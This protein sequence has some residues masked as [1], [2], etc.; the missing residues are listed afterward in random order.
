[1]KN[2]FR[3]TSTHD[4]L[5]L[6]RY[7]MVAPKMVSTW[8][9]PQHGKKDIQ[10]K[11]WLY[12]FLMTASKQI[13]RISYKIMWVSLSFFSIHSP[14]CA[15]P[16]RISCVDQKM[17]AKKKNTKKKTKRKNYQG[18]LPA[19]GV[20]LLL[21]AYPWCELNSRARRNRIRNNI[22]HSYCVATSKQQQRAMKRLT[23]PPTM[24]TPPPLPRVP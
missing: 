1:M 15:V 3:S 24:M 5:L 18:I 7:R 21:L 2:W 9:L 17:Q 11:G 4:F 10:E 13:I 8:T 23:P 16:R 6:F 20:L 14:L 19:L 22:S 12:P